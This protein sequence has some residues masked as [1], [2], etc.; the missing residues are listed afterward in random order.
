MAEE[1]RS[2]HVARHFTEE[3]KG[4][5]IDLQDKD[6]NCYEINLV[7]TLVCKILTMKRI[8]PEIFKSMII[9]IWGVEGIKI[10]NAGR[11]IYL[12]PFR[13]QKDKQQIV[14]EGPWFFDK[15]LLL[16]E[17]P[18]ANTSISELDFRYVYFWI[19]FHELPLAGF[20]RNVAKAIGEM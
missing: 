2:K 10:K 13:Y 7:N 1:L 11:N 15:L 4:Q 20:S 18:K 9:R 17:E 19:H 12:C 14:K 16:F 8:S 3:E 6:I 5:Q